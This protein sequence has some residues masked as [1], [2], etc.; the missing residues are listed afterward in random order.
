MVELKLEFKIL[1]SKIGA[2]RIENTKM[3]IEK[4]GKQEILKFKM[5]MNI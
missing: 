2:K 4:I 5:K 1:N 3:E